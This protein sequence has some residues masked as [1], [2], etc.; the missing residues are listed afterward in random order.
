MKK[1]FLATATAIILFG[2]TFGSIHHAYAVS[3][4][5]AAAEAK[6]AAAD[7]RAQAAAEKGRMLQAIK[8]AAEYEKQQMKQLDAEDARRSGKTDS[9][10]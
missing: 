1:I 5:E 8:E 9:S 10:Q 7:A 6:A 3:D 2:A 4:A